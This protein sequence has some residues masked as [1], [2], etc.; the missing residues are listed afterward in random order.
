M[1]GL[2]SSSEPWDDRQKAMVTKWMEGTYKQF[3]ERV[4]KTRAGKIKDIDKVA[5]GRI[6]LAKDAK[7]LGMVDEIGGIDD[8]LA[9]AAKNVGLESGKYDIRI[10]P[11]PKTLG[12]ILMGNGADAAFAFKPTVQINPDSILVAALSPAMRKSMARQM[13]LLQVLRDCPVVLMAPY[14]VTIK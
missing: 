1:P 5:R 11:A 3:T 9:Y 13:Q 7:A 14:S 12:D 6:F 4:M 10:V 2:F 8:A